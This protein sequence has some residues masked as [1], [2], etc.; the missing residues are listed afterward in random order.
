MI[1][2]TNLLTLSEFQGIFEQSVVPIGL[3]V[4]EITAQ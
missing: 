1:R 3:I 4:S 2:K